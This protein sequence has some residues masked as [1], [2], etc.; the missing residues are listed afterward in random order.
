MRKRKRQIPGLEGVAFGV[1]WFSASDWER[2]KEV[3]PDPDRLEATYEEWVSMATDAL[4]DLKRAGVAPR[5][6]AVDVEELLARCEQNDLEPDGSSRA[7][8]A[9]NKLREADLSGQG[10]K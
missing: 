1:A 10:T 2:L 6:V 9:A 8:F 7:H 5:K 3:V 4:A